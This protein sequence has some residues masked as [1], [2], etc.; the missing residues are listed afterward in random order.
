VVEDTD[1]LRPAAVAEAAVGLQPTKVAGDELRA[2][3]SWVHVWIFQLELMTR[4]RNA[5]LLYTT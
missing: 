4:N 5:Y 3:A 2:V 1:G